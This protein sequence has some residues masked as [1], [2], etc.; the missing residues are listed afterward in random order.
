MP[1]DADPEEFARGL[2]A[3]YVDGARRL[4]LVGT[5]RPIPLR[6]FVGARE[7]DDFYLDIAS[8]GAG[9]FQPIF[10]IDMFVT[11]VPRRRRRLRASR[12]EPE[13][14]RRAARVSSPYA[15]D[16]VYDTIAAEFTRLGFAVTRNPL[17]HRPTLGTTL[18][19]ARLTELASQPANSALV[20][21]S[22]SY[23]RP[24]QRT[25][26]RSRCGAGTT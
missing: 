16:D 21:R 10:H 18:S 11:L 13:A 8:E 6:D 23:P 19:F 5:R 3:T 7:G 15:L 9:T 26:P 20:P 24:A 17:V 25:R 1:P 4:I 2:F 12:G 14:R 22:P